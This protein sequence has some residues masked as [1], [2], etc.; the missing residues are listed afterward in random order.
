M[1]TNVKNAAIQFAIVVAALI[2]VIGL[3]SV[4]LEA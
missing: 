2:F 4:E 1:D 3:S